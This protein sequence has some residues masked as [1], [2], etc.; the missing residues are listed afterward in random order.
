MSTGRHR[1][2]ELVVQA[3]YQ[4]L[5]NPQP[6]Q[7]LLRHLRETEPDGFDQERCQQLLDGLTAH[8][9]GLDQ[10]IAHFI[11]RPVTALSP[12]EHAVLLLGAEELAHYPDVPYRVAINEA[13]E[14]AK[15]FGGTD[16]HKFVNGVM[17]KLAAV[18]RP[19]EFVARRRSESGK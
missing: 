16:G 11:D 6:V 2:R 13:V 17:D 18:L 8:A 7:A 3:L 9:T 19:H 4:W 1:T 14:L 5:L 10:Q 12:V 15:T